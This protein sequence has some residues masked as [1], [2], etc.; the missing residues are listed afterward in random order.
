MVKAFK[1]AGKR[2]KIFKKLS[3][4]LQSR[5][6]K[7]SQLLDYFSELKSWAAKAR[8]EKAREGRQQE[9]NDDKE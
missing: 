2:P 9:K 7:A 3:T 4:Q 5:K 6:E 8:W 1:K